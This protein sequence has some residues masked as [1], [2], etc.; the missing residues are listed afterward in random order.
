MSNTNET[1]PSSNLSP[2]DTL[3]PGSL[4][5]LHSTWHFV[6]AQIRIFGFG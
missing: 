3:S 2:A 6:P 4:R 1:C 5:S